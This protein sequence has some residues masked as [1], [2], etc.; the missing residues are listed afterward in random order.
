MERDNPLKFW[1]HEEGRAAKRDHPL[2]F[3]QQ[4]KGRAA[5]RDCFRDLKK[6]PVAEVGPNLFSLLNERFQV[7][8]Q[9]VFYVQ[10]FYY[11]CIFFGG[12]GC[13]GH[14]FAYVAHF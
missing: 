4:E 12:L 3:W 10:S 11:F 14:S 13:V 9:K 8:Q 2:K 7:L 6:S 1:K 5:E